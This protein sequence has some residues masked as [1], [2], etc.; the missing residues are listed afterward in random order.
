ML[1]DALRLETEGDVLGHREMR[2][3]RVVL[4]DHAEAT[5]RRRESR[6]VFPGY[7]DR[8]FVELLEA[9]DCAQQRRL[10]AATRPK[11]N[12]RLPF[13]NLETYVVEYRQLTKA[14][15]EILEMKKRAHPRPLTSRSHCRIH[16]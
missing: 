8:A 14:L 6:H 9:G 16:S 3:E 13:R 2:E 10:P 5:A 12:E 15:G 11:E 4:K 1:V 7:P